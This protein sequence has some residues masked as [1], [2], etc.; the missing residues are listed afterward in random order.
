MPGR[1]WLTLTAAVLVAGVVAAL[2]APRAFSGFIRHFSVGG[3]ITDASEGGC[4]GEA[5]EVGSAQGAVTAPDGGD[6][7]GITGPPH[8]AFVP[9]GIINP[10]HTVYLPAFEAQKMRLCDNT[11]KTY[12]CERA[13]FHSASSED[14]WDTQIILQPRTLKRAG[15]RAGT[16]IKAIAI[17]PYPELLDA[18][19]ALERVQIRYK[20]VPAGYRFVHNPSPYFFD[21]RPAST[22]MTL[23]FGPFP[24]SNMH[25]FYASRAQ[26]QFD[27]FVELTASSPTWDGS[28]ALVLGLK[29]SYWGVSSFIPKTQPNNGINN[30]IWVVDGLGSDA[31]T[32]MWSS[33]KKGTCC[34]GC[35]TQECI[36]CMPGGPCSQTWI[37]CECEYIRK[38]PF[39]TTDC[40]NKYAH[41]GSGTYG[42]GASPIIP[43]FSYAMKVKLKI[44]DIATIQSTDKYQEVTDQINP[45]QAYWK[46]YKF[47]FD[48]NFTENCKIR[49]RLAQLT[50]PQKLGLHVTF[51]QV[52]YLGMLHDPSK[53]QYVASDHSLGV[54]IPYTPMKVVF[55]GVY[56]EAS[57]QYQLRI[58]PE[59]TPLKITLLQEEQGAIPA[60]PEYWSK[61]SSGGPNYIIPGGATCGGWVARI[62]ADPGA[63]LP[64]TSTVKFGTANCPVIHVEPKYLQCTAPAGVGTNVPVTVSAGVRTSNA[65]SFSY[66][67]PTIDTRIVSGGTLRVFGSN[68]GTTGATVSVGGKDCPVLSQGLRLGGN[69]HPLDQEITCTLPAGGGVN[70]PVTVTVAGQHSNT[71]PV[72]YN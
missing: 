11:Y 10:T 5:S 52:P 60:P 34:Y 43:G 67:P 53:Y 12:E 42:Q 18:Q 35:S 14:N 62:W 2:I 44:P 16:S 27:S 41:I 65:L 22:A 59:L 39:D 54:T 63:P 45:S 32:I 58:Q 8:P 15:L 72:S 64:P 29:G 3:K 26:P 24:P 46:Y 30:G 55:I 51:G 17:A 23:G 69:A 56:A 40:G 21:D 25:L 61:L 1:K 7:S 38:S 49:I 33:G 6:L 19:V 47:S 4:G 20:W 37:S 13:F 48:K 66:A 50:G 68:L 70:L 57:T 9:S 71:V 31:E 28:S 36:C